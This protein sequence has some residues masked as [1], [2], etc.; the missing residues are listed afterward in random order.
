VGCGVSRVLTRDV[1]AG[2]MF[3]GFA[4]WGF[5]A[6]ADLEAGTAGDIGPAYVPRLICAALLLLGLL[7]LGVGLIQ[8]ERV[9]LPDWPLRP[10]GLVTLSC[11]AFALLLQ[12]AGIVAAITATV[13]IGSF[14]GTPPRV[15]A[16]VLLCAA[17]T[18]ACIALFIWGLGL[19]IPI[20]PV[21]QA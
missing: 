2:L 19:P 9:P 21:G 8:A 14:A 10:I 11:L 7:I 17:L 3:V 12:R 16:L 4:L 20:W 1:F 6:G 18:L 13:V 5:W 15:P